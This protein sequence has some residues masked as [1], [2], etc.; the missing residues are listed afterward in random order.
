[1]RELIT[2]RRRMER[3]DAWK[4]YARNMGSKRKKQSFLVATSYVVVRLNCVSEFKNTETEKWLNMH[5][6]REKKRDF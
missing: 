6:R 3:R 4:E 1:M 2:Q 5:V